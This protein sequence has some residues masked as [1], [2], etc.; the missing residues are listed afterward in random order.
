MN[1]YN[2]SKT[3]TKLFN[4]LGNSYIT[5]TFDEEPFLFSVYLK[6]GDPMFDEKDYLA[7]VHTTRF[8]PKMFRSKKNPKKTVSVEKVRQKFEE[9]TSYLDIVANEGKTIQV[10]FMDMDYR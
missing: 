10:R 3:L 5:E 4:S 2:T 9:M 1:L 8:I 7:E 6:R